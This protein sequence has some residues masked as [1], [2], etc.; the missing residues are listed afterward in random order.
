MIKKRFFVLHLKCMA[1]FRQIHVINYVTG[2]KGK[3]EQRNI[4]MT[5]AKIVKF[6]NC[7]E[8]FKIFQKESG[9]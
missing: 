6:K 7:Q 5:P 2:E 1:C 9:K 3:E 8:K 4:L